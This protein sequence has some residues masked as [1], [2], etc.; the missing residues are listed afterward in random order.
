MAAVIAYG[1]GTSLNVGSSLS[2]KGKAKKAAK[3]E[4]ALQRLMTSEEL[5]TLGK[6]Q[7]AVLGGARS[8]IAASGFTGYGASSEAYLNDLQKEQSMQTQF[9]K[10]V[11]GERAGA[12]RRQGQAQASGYGYEALSSLIGGA[13]KIGGAFNWGLDE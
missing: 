13:T 12:I 10:Q 9:T 7:E 8:Q 3:K 1:L 2:A 4:E 6:E 5:R 11:G